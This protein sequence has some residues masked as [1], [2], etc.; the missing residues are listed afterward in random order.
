MTTPITGRLLCWWVIRIDQRESRELVCLFPGNLNRQFRS[1]VFSYS[2]LG[3]APQL[4]P[5]K[6]PIDQELWCCAINAVLRL[7]CNRASAPVAFS[8]VSKLKVDNP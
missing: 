5:A 2:R 7:T 4:I 3:S 8:Q 1:A 6:N